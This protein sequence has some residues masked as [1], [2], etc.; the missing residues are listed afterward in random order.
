[1]KLRN[2]SSFRARFFC[3]FYVFSLCS[4]A[5]SC[6]LMR[7]F[8]LYTS[9][10]FFIIFFSFLYLHAIFTFIYLPCT[11]LFFIFY[12]LFLIFYLLTH[13]IVSIIS[14]ARKRLLILRL[15]FLR[16]QLHFCFLLLLPLHQSS[17]TAFSS[18]FL[19]FLLSSL[20]S[21]YLFNQSSVSV[22]S[23]FFLFSFS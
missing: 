7:T 10:T 12:L 11:F 8:I 3:F 20:S 6:V 18:F 22:F 15:L 17:V 5:C 19:F 23:S 1:M 4:F 2:R 21:F 14:R 16:V 13:M 9:Y